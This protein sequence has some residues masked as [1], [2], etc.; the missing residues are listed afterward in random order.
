MPHVSV[1]R[2]KGYTWDQ[3]AKIL[4]QCGF[5]LQSKTLSGYFRELFKAKEKVADSWSNSTNRSQDQLHRISAENFTLADEL[6]RAASIVT[7]LEEQQS[8]EKL[9]PYL[10]FLR[11]EGC[12]WAKIAK[13]LGEDD[14][15]VQVSTLRSYFSEIS[16]S[17][18]NS[19]HQKMQEQAA[20]LAKIR[21]KTAGA[22]FSEIPYR[23]NKY[24]S[25]LQ[26]I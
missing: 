18:N 6:L 3:I 16:A 14:F 4:S 7:S 20:A 5:N 2:S 19:W 26:Q 1:L 10:Y 15:K 22:D 9:M 8:F 12:T 25:I 24:I 17:K 11:N 21:N 13:L 23:V